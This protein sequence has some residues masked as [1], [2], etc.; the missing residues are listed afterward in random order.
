LLTISP[1]LLKTLADSS[2]DLTLETSPLLALKPAVADTS[3]T[4]HTPLIYNETEFRWALNE[5][6]MAS[7]KLAEGIRAFAADTLKLEQWLLSLA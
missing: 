4:S 6:A 5:D 7:E 3:T 2:V 1:D